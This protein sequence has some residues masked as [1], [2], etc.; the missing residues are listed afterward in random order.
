M[1]I[2][3]DQRSFEHNYVADIGRFENAVPTSS[4]VWSKAVNAIY[5]L[6]TFFDHCSC[7][8]CRLKT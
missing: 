1:P 8:A 5:L 2:K 7:T 6:L 4:L 3:Y